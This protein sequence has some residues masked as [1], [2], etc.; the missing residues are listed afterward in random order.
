MKLKQAISDYFNDRNLVIKTLLV[1]V[2]IIFILRLIDL[3]LINGAEYR[4]LSKTKMLRTSAQEAP[5][6]TIYD[7]NGVILATSKIGYDVVLYATDI[8]TEELNSIL[9]KVT[10]II[11]G[12]KDKVVSNLTFLDNKI[13]F[14]SDNVKKSFLN[15]YSLED[16]ISDEQIITF[17]Y[18]KYKLK[19]SEYTL[20]E[21]QKILKLRYE[22]AKN[23]YS[24]F[25]YVTIARNVSYETMAYIEEIK[26]ELGGIVVLSSPKRYYTRGTSLAHVLGYVSSISS[27]EYEELKDS[28][29]SQ[30]S[31]IGKM[32]IESF[33]EP[34]LKGENGVIRTEVDALGKVAS[35]Y[36]YKEAKSGN[37]VALTIDYRLQEI[38][39]Q[40]LEEVIE[41]LK[42]EKDGK[43][44]DANAGAVVITNVN[45]GEVL[46]LASY[47]SFDPNLFISGISYDDWN[48]LNTNDTRP[49]FNRAT[50]GVYPPGSTF[51][52]I[53][54]LAGLETGKITATE[55]IQDTGVYSY[56]YN[57]VCW[58]YTDY[59][60]THG[61]ITVSDAIK[62]SCNCYFYEVGRRTGVKSLV[63][64]A[65]M[66]GLAS[67][68][69]IE[70]QESLGV[71]AGTQDIDWY[72]GDTLSASI[73]QSYNSFTPV[74]L[75]NY[76][77]AIANG[78]TLNR[79][80]LIKQ[81]GD[82]ETQVDYKEIKKFVEE[83]TGV[84]DIS[85]VVDVHEENI[86]VVKDGMKRSSLETGGGTYYVFGNNNVEV[87]GKTGT[88]EVGSGSAN[89]LF[90]GFAPANNPEIAIVAVIEHGGAG[91]NAA[92]VARKIAQKYY[93]ILEQ[94]NNVKSNQNI[95]YPNIGF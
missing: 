62:V 15:T 34:Y 45:T 16:N 29:Y 6:G 31:I 77:A 17:L 47:P 18:D 90:G 88:A 74:Q 61:Y 70:L 19:D 68:T 38:S 26:S 23:G 35:E 10:N 95:S 67:K 13:V 50:Q 92:V 4:E 32:G 80:T 44:K 12:N 81:I 79:L 75:V 1:I 41:G 87:A 83:K 91:Q 5:R 22:I 66:F 33:L 20:A 3:Q 78:G 42:Q 14:S 37:D 52:M 43:Y 28:G 86:E 93:D 63:Q 82:N 57:P 54:A 51:K 94:E 76:I 71:I 58:I 46:A 56:S 53:S 7:T 21:K 49:M 59:G 9:L 60:R 89:A 36:V 25:R 69:G 39:E 40:A 27:E 55:L 30:N 2:A 8:T 64:Y 72:L 48:D 85:K 73:G 65:E 11:E 24:L 84:E